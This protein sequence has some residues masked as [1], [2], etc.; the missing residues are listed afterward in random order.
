MTERVPLHEIS[1]HVFTWVTR[2]AAGIWERGLG[3]WKHS[4][5][6]QIGR[7]ASV[8]LWGFVRGFSYRIKKEIASRKSAKSRGL[9]RN[10]LTDVAFTVSIIGN[11]ISGHASSIE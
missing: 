1:H 7:Q 4:R 5:L 2:S 8:N 3:I 10:V 9:G 11:R 6:S